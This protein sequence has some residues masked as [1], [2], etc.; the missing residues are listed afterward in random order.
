M[1]YF[2]KSTWFEDEEK[3]SDPSKNMVEE[4]SYSISY[5]VK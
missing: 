1:Y 4:I 2:W 3:L 5:S